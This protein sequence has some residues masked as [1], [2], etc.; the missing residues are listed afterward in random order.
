MEGGSVL[1]SIVGGAI[2]LFLGTL[3]AF[4]GYRLFLILPPIYGF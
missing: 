4:G 3:V 1:G 2:V